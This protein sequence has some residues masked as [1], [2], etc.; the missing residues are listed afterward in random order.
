VHLITSSRTQTSNHLHYV[1][2]KKKSFPFPAL[3]S[4]VFSI[5][6]FRILVKSAK[7]QP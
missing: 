4:L 3:N 6:Q 1:S 7:G 2:G 5:F